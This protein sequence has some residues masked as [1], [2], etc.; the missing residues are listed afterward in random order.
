MLN[1]K[2]R[3]IEDEGAQVVIA[4]GHGGARSKTHC[5]S[6]TA[7]DRPRKQTKCTANNGNYSTLFATLQNHRQNELMDLVK[8]KDSLVGFTQRA[9]S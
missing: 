1:R 7:M 8:F 2:W 5:K 3:H 6:V 9:R 4:P